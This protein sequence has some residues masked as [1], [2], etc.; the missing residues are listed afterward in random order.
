MRLK[1]IPLV[2]ILAAAMLGG[3]ATQALAEPTKQAKIGDLVR[4]LGYGGAIH[5]FKNYVLRGDEK[6]RDGADQSFSKAQ[7][8]VVSL[9][10]SDVSGAE[11]AAL[12]NIEQTISAYQAALKVLHEQ[13]GK[14]LGVGD[15]VASAN[16]QLKVDDA[17]A[18]AGLDTLRAGHQW[19]DVENMEFVLGYGGAIH[20]FKNFLL[21]GEKKYEEK[22]LSDFSRALELSDN[23][24][25]TD[26]SDAERTA[27]ADLQKTL[28]GYKKGMKVAEKTAL[29][30]SKAKAKTVIGMA[31]HSADK[32][33]KVDDASALSGLAVLRQKYVGPVAD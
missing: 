8:I 29:Y 16:A 3:I 6:Y 9:R 26:L 18:L 21:R 10:Q 2:L 23:I 5:D 20:Q 30:V 12:D 25:K 17:P 27:L 14:G 24:S 4:S 1:K 15:I 22:A 11:S 7:E 19:N 28:K 13:V 33:V 32:K 31:I